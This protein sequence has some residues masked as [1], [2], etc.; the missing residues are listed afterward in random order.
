MDTIAVILRGVSK[1]VLLLCSNVDEQAKCPDYRGNYNE[2][3][4]L[5]EVSLYLQVMLIAS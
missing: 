3:W 1:E 2:R 4:S 5:R